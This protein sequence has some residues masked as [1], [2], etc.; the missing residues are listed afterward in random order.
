[1]FDADIDTSDHYLC[2]I[3][4]DVDLFSFH[5]DDDDGETMMIMVIILLKIVTISGIMKITIAVFQTL[6]TMEMLMTTNEGRRGGGSSSTN[7]VCDTR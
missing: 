4:D 6:V 7:L 1:M 3:E 5:D 2:D